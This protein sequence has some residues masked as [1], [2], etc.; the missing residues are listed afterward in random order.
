MRLFAKECAVG[1][2]TNFTLAGFRRCPECMRGNTPSK[3]K[4]EEE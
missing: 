2:C 3:R 4:Q 1:D